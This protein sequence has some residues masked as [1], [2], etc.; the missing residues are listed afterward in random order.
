[1]WKKFSGGVKPK[2][3]MFGGGG[4]SGG[5]EGMGARQQF[6]VEKKDTSLRTS[7]PGHRQSVEKWFMINLSC[8]CESWS[9]CPLRLFHWQVKGHISMCVYLTK[10]L[11]S[12]TNY[13][14]HF[15]L[16]V[17]CCQSFLSLLSH[18]VVNVSTEAVVHH[19]VWS[20]LA[21]PDVRAC[22]PHWLVSHI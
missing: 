20:V 2:L 18:S 1:M 10:Q 11:S 21:Q 13:L 9:T 15:N 5:V 6:S 16:C 12:S 4:G 7:A 8:Q 14:Q 17:S 19:P 3:W 22:S